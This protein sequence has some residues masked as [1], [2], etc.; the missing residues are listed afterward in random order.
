VEYRPIVPIAMLDLAETGTP[1]EIPAWI[2]LVLWP[3]LIVWAVAL[4]SARRGHR[5][6][7]SAGLG[8]ALSGLCLGVDGATLTAA[9]TWPTP[10]ADSFVFALLWLAALLSVSAYLVLRAPHGGDDGGS[11]G[12]APEPPWW[13]EFERQFRDYTR[14]GPR[15]PARS[16]RAPVGAP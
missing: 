2:H 11:D 16:P 4:R 1:L 14:A 7:G 12:D 3:L 8:F 5:L 10:A 13:P 9:V 6:L 15:T